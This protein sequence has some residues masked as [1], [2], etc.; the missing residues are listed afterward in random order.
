MYSPK[1]TLPLPM[2]KGH[3]A[4]K[5]IIASILLSSFLV[6]A[7]I[8]G[9]GAVTTTAHKISYN[10]YVETGTLWEYW[11]QHTLY[12]SVTQSL[13]EYYLGR[14][15]SSYPN[16]EYLKF[17]TP[18]AVLPIAE[19]IWSICQFQ[20]HGEEQFTNAVLMFVHQIP[21]ESTHPP[22]Y[23]VETLV[24]NKGD[25]DTFSLLAASVLKAKEFD[26]ILLY[27]ESE[28]HMNI[29]V[30]LP[31]TPVYSRD[32]AWYISYNSKNY[33]IA[34]CTGYCNGANATLGWRVGECPDNLKQASA[35][36]I[37]L[38]SV[39][40]TPP[41][42]VSA[43]V[44]NDL[45][46]SYFATLIISPSSPYYVGEQ[47][48]IES[49]I[50]PVHSG[51]NVVLYYRKGM[52]S[53]DVWSTTRMD[54]SG[55]FSFTVMFSSK[56]T[57]Y[58]R[59]SWSGDADHEGADSQILSF[60]VSLAPS[61]IHLMLSTSTIYVGENVTITGYISPIHS[62][63]TVNLYYS[64]D[65]DYWLLL[66]QVDTDM[67]GY[68]SCQWAPTLAE[69]FYIKAVWLG[70]SDHQGATS[71]VQTL[72]VNKASSTLTL[73]LSSSNINLGNTVILSG[74]ILPTHQY[75][76]VDLYISENGY[77]WN[78]L[79]TVITD[80]QG[81]YTYQWTPTSTG[82]YYLKAYWLGD[83]DH[84]E[85]ESNV[86]ILTVSY[87]PP[88][89]PDDQ[90]TPNP[91]PPDNQNT[92]TSPPNYLPLILLPSLVAVTVCLLIILRKRG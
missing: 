16:S 58:F 29:G 57:Y 71:D 49:T 48:R 85:D 26:I 6:L 41:A 74:E 83:A 34:E 63:Q 38:D 32:G 76:N 2:A 12:V 82:T 40:T 88:T 54:S 53:W 15:H 45:S 21:Y 39:E 46:T 78:F 87:S 90:G 69:T 79:A 51:K 31:E 59:V 77:Q 66:T 35:T 92:E 61:S 17:V 19:R 20:S 18:N 72:I 68:F 24:N 3:F 9:Y 67:D 62:Y 13:Y 70:D 91:A 36:I 25:C 7:I 52:G 14:D 89:N 27:W 11:E 65:G 28:S 8:P 55:T 47:V 37:P 4:A 44:D 75:A 64:M 81:H 33:Y 1:S 73:L 50:A 56:G 23:P 86:S 42:Q 80:T 84:T 10:F 5:V 30:Y 22:T 43:S 60:D